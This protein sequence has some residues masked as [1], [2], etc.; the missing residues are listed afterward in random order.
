LNSTKDGMLDFWIGVDGGGSGTRAL[1]ALPSG[2]VLG[3]GQ[4]GPSALGQ[5]IEAAWKQVLLAVHQAFASAGL[6][7]AP[8]QK[9]ALGAG[10]SGVHNVAWRDAFLAHNP[11]FG[12]LVLESDAS[13]M[14]LGAHGGR[15]GVMVAA[16]TGSVGEALYPD[17][18]RASVGGWGFP[19]GDEGSGA[20]MGLQAVRLAQAAMDGRLNPSP[21]TQAILQSCGVTRDDL[22]AWSARAG[23]FEY[24]ALAP[25][26]FASQGQDSRADA[27]IDQACAELET[28]AQALDPKGILPLAICGSIGDLLK[29]RMHQGLQARMV[30]PQ[31][32]PVEG[33]L[34]LLKTHPRSHP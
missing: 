25:L 13:T 20:W 17:G 30:S 18:S 29:P 24:A 27:I 3:R 15:P 19:V 33:A 16:G 4:A 9:C 34:E 14:L 5:G 22:Q 2:V 10:L 7:A 8:P 32:G 31:A 28:M 11:G 12:V 26:V 23:Q 6:P 21:L 1:L